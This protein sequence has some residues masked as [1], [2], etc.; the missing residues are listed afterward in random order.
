MTELNPTPGPEAGPPGDRSIPPGGQP[1]TPGQGAGPGDL[2]VTPVPAAASERDQQMQAADERARRGDVAGA[3][4]DLTRM[5]EQ[6][7]DDAVLLARRGGYAMSV[8][9]VE[10]AEDDIR[11][12]IRADERNAEAHMHLGVLLCRRARW[13]E[14]IDPL[15][16]ATEL[17]P[18]S[19]TAHYQLGDAFNQTDRLQEALVAYET[20]LRLDP[21]FWRA[22]KGMGIILDRMGR[23]AEASAAY[24][25]VRELQRR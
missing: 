7:P 25:R 21:T 17:A 20:A 3:I 13:R 4:A 11:R 23:P 16:R 18:T 24:Q 10:Q 5:L 2:P 15:R 1:G 12:A 22:L 6:R 8:Q 19:V 9:R 14:A